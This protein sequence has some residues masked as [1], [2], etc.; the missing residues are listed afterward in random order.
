MSRS[1]SPVE[2]SFMKAAPLKWIQTAWIGIDCFNLLAIKNVNSY[3][4]VNDVAGNQWAVP[5]YL[6]GRLLNLRLT[7]TF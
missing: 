1:F 5:N 7:A 2:D 6:T 3:Y 4:W